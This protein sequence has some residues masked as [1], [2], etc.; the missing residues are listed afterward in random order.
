M[1]ISLNPWGALGL[2]FSNWWVGTLF[3]VSSYLNPRTSVGDDTAARIYLP[4]LCDFRLEFRNSK[5]EAQINNIVL[6]LCFPAL[7]Q[8]R[9]SWDCSYDS[10]CYLD[11]FYQVT[12]FDCFV[13]RAVFCYDK[14]GNIVG[15][16]VLEWSNLYRI[17]KCQ[18]HISPWS[19]H[20][21]YWPYDTA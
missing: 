21:P 20:L 9:I 2:L 10:I 18:K 6:Y 16:H 11:R 14:A 15:S 3:E 13:Q 19:L 8:R 12:H 1:C 7:I 5:I 17:R 4:R